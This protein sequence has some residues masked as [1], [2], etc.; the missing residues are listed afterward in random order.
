MKS[1]RLFLFSLLG[2]LAL[3]APAAQAS[4]AARVYELRT[5]TATP[6]NLEVLVA[7][8]RENTL[9]I[10]AKHGMKN[11]GYWLPMDEKAGAGQKIVYLL[12]YPSRDAAKA[13]W[14][15]FSADPEWQAVRKKTEANGKIV[16]H[17]DSIYLAPT[18]YAKPMTAGNGQGAPRVFELRTYTTAE[19]KLDA[20]DA[21][22]R[23][24]TVAIFARHGMTSLGYF[25]PLDADKGAANTLVYLLAHANREAA[26]ASWKA[27]QADADWV[28]A[29]KASEAN[30]KLTT[31]VESVFLT[32]TDFSPVK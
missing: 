16:D 9:R 15:S 1:L 13:S 31:K 12:S 29:R 5:Y 32:P 27:F 14:K 4:E 10:F 24:H 3:A 2:C 17:V 23:D 19:G 30:G 18:D 11:E 7:R 26:T 25:H 6:G 22:F 8:F 28:K 20:L 21:R